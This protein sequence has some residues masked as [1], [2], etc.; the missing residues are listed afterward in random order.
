MRTTPPTDR[1]R[2]PVRLA[3]LAALGLLTLAGPAGAG[4]QQPAIDLDRY[5][6]SETPEDDFHLSRPTDLGHLRFGA[7]LHVDYGLNPLVVERTLGDASS[8]ERSAVEHQL[9]GT[10]GLSFGLFDRLVV[11]GGLPVVLV[12]DGAGAD[13]LAPYGVAPAGGAGLGNAYAGARVRLLGED[14]DVGALAVQAAFAFPTAGVPEDSVYRGEADVS[15]S[16]E[17]VAELRP[18]LGARVVLDVGATVRVEGEAASTNLANRHALTFGLGFAMPV[19]TD[20]DP[21]THLD[22]HAQIYGSTSFAE[23]FSREGTP[24]EATAGAKL[25]HASGLVFGLAGGPGLSRGIGTP[26]LRLVGSVGWMIPE[27]APEPPAPA[28]ADGDGVLDDACPARAEDLDG[29]QD[30][31]GCP[32][33]DDDG[34]GIADAADACR[35]EAETING[36]EDA[37]GCPDEVPDTDGDGVRDDVD[38]CAGEPEDADGFADEDGCPDPDDDEDGVADASD[39]CPREAGPVANGGCPD[40][41][42]DGDSVVDRLDNCVDEPGSPEHHGC[43]EAQRVAIVE[44][45]LEILDRVYFR[46]NRARIRRRSHALLEN[47]ASVLNEHPEIEQVVVEGHTDARGDRAHNVELSQARAQAV[48]DFL[49]DRGVDRGRLEARGFGPDRPVVEGASSADEH[50]QNRRVEFRIPGRDAAETE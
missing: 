35:A 14:D 41:D 40:T 17:L 16:P 3:A 46:T 26:D 36:F 8:E 29:H 44:G 49:A 2:G 9:V 30:A 32:D 27:A 15:F 25:F 11:F 37:D 38:A 48:V 7:Q 18:G 19:W 43:V 28:D 45:G 6:A 10:V 31:D 39:R 13:A 33:P 50:A 47:V 5:G 23:P 22:V 20:A 42:R 12:N 24:L 1:P 21:R 34:D 4:A